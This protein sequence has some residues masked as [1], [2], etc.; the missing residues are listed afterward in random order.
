MR[1]DLDNLPK[2]KLLDYIEILSKNWL[3]HDGC[4]FLAIEYDLGLEA[5]MKYD[6]TGWEYFS[7]IEAKRIKKFP[8]PGRTPG[9]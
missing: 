6:K 7:V 2:E 3:A 4:W 9:H 8:G 5:A 1:K